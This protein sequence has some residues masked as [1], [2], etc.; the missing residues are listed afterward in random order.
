MKRKS[1]SLAKAESDRNRRVA[2]SSPARGAIQDTGTAF[3]LWVSI[4]I[5]VRIERKG[6]RRVY[7][8]AR[9]IKWE[10]EPTKETE[11]QK[12]SVSTL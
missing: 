3:I 6:S 2:G 4:P 9:K 11:G 12:L 10:L 1:G 5:E 7:V 8:K